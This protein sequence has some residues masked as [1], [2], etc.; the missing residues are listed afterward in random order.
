MSMCDGEHV[1]NH[2][3]VLLGEWEYATAS[4]ID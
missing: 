3:P 4:H 2:V 1:H